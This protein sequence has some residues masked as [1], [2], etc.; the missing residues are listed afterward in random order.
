MHSWALGFLF[1]LWFWICWFQSLTKAEAGT[2][3]SNMT[4]SSSMFIRFNPLTFSYSVTS[5]IHH[6]FW[7]IFH[8]CRCCLTVKVCYFH[9]LGRHILM[10][11]YHLNYSRLF[12]YNVSNVCYVLIKNNRRGSPRSSRRRIRRYQAQLFSITRTSC[13]LFYHSSSL[14]WLFFFFFVDQRD[15]FLTLFSLWAFG[16]F[17]CCLFIFLR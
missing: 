4:I 15:C 6:W 17:I 16:Y 13:S 1:L 10:Q 9:G 11:F 12:L 14:E 5:I 2:G 3:L 7:F 8:W